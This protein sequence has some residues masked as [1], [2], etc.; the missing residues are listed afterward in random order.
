[1]FG[2]RFYRYYSFPRVETRKLGSILNEIPL[3]VRNIIYLRNFFRFLKT[4]YL[5]NDIEITRE[6]SNRDRSRAKSAQIVMK[7]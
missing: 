4:D 5:P 2:K 6:V 1:M 3:I 7:L